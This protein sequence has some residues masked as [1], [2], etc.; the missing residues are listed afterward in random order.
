[1]NTKFKI[2]QILNVFIDLGDLEE[3]AAFPIPFFSFILLS[4]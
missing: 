1:M 4:F 3:Y 2:S